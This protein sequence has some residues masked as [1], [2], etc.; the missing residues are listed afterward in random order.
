[1]YT[2]CKSTAIGQPSCPAAHDACEMLSLGVTE[3]SAF[4]SNTANFLP[5][6]V[7]GALSDMSC[8]LGSST[9]PACI[10]SQG[11]SQIDE[12]AT[13]YTLQT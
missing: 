1:M 8:R 3:I 10:C 11:Q 9:T 12:P 7:S 6:C 13:F 4:T 2:W 5:G